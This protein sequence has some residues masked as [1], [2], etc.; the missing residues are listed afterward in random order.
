VLDR[1][2]R[3]HGEGLVLIEGAATGAD[4][5]A[6]GW[7]Q[8]NS[9]G[10]ERHRCHPVDWAAE[11]KARPSGWKMA[12]PERNTRM[13]LTDHPCLIVAFHDHFDPTSG[14]TSDICARALIRS[15]PVWL[16]HGEN[17]NVGR[18]L[19][20]E[21]FPSDRLARIHRELEVAS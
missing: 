2:A 11:R 18:W 12:G 10:P 5:A 9:L 15:V 1:L 7:C 4:L 14:G 3:R 6:H 19:R 13:L 16:V 8:A 21:L 17:P 20:P